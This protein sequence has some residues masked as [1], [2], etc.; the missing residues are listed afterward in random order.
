MCIRDSS[1]VAA[2]MHHVP[3]NELGNL[4]EDVESDVLVCSDHS[5]A[6]EKTSELLTKIPGI[7]PLDAGGLSNATAIEAF[8]AVILQLNSR[9]KTRA[10]LRFIGIEEN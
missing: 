10:A 6:T 7:R 4:N 5:K 9:Y 3:A 8:S 2:A 1:Y